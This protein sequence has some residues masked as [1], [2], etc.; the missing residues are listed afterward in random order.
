MLSGLISLLLSSTCLV[1]FMSR[2]FSCLLLSL[3][4][5]FGFMSGMF[6]GLLLSLPCFLGFMLSML[7]YCCAVRW[8][9]LCWT[10]RFTT[11]PLGLQSL[12]P[13]DSQDQCKQ[14]Y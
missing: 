13:K 6:S 4:C 12:N 10:I 5:F 14:N 7:V 9:T 3:P 8:T 11:F 1:G 2:M